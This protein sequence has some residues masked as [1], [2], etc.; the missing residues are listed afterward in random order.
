MALNNLGQSR[1]MWITK[2]IGISVKNGTL[3]FNLA[4]KGVS[5]L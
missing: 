4:I 3:P 2:I 1:L 5:T